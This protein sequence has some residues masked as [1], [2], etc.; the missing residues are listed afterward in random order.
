MN[1]ENIF[2]LRVSKVG[3]SS[4]CLIN[5]FQEATAFGKK[6]FTYL[7]D[8]PLISRK[9][10]LAFALYKKGLRFGGSFSFR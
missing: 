1:S 10:L 2:G 4:K 8:L 9:L 5:I 3:M 6:L 7:D